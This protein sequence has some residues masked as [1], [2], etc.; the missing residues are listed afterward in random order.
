MRR[1]QKGQLHCRFGCT[2]KHKKTPRRHRYALFAFLCASCCSTTADMS[3]KNTESAL[4]SKAVGSSPACLFGMGLVPRWSVELF[5]LIIFQ[6][7]LS[8]SGWD[9]YS[10]R[11]VL[12][13]DALVGLS[14]LLMPSFS[15]KRQFLSRFLRFNL[16]SPRVKTAFRVGRGTPMMP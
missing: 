16:T 5:E 15:Y 11:R 9:L 12:D 7:R 14:R 1:C 13:A 4:S 10:P 6:G 3:T 2:S 8:K